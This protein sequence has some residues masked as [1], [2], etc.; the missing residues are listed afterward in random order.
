MISTKWYRLGSLRTVVQQ[1]AGVAQAVGDRHADLLPVHH[2]LAFLD[3]L[4]A[5]DRLDLD[6]HQGLAG[7]QL[8]RRPDGRLHHA[9]GGPEDH[10]GPGRQAQRGIGL[11]RLDVQKSMPADLIIQAAS[12]VVTTIVHAPAAVDLQLGPGRLVLLGRAAH[13]GNRED[14]LRVD[15]DL[16]REVALDHGPVHGHGRLAGRDVLDQ[17]R[18]EL[19]HALHPGAG[20]GGDQRQSALALDPLQELAGLLHDRQVRGELGVKD[21]V[22]AQLSQGRHE[23]AF[24]VVARLQAEGLADGGPDR[25]GELGHLDHGRVV[26]P[27]EHLLRVVLFDECRRGTDVD[28]LAAAGTDD[29]CMGML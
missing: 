21:V 19:L 29:S 2:D 14:L 5:P 27:V 8:I 3:A 15:A 7:V 26:E 17:V 1:L 22:E 4:Q 11:L 6:V 20:T 10:A 12:R 24:H 28:A 16:V 13:D 23:L 9:A 18:I 25:R